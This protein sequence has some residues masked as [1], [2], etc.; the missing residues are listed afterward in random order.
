VNVAVPQ[1]ICAGACS[2]R[3]TSGV[4]GGVSSAG[5]SAPL[6]CLSAV[7]I[8]LKLAKIIQPFNDERAKL[9]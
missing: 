4:A 9:Y 5:R 1:G 7:L 6:V 3:A 2:E 8:Y